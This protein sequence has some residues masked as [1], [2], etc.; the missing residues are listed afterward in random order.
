MKN[1]NGY[2]VVCKHKGQKTTMGI[3]NMTEENPIVVMFCLLYSTLFLEISAS[4]R[5]S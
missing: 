2:Y 4:P 1:S 3:F 5:T